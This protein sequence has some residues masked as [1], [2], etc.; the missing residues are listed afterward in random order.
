MKIVETNFM[1][2]KQKIAKRIKYNKHVNF[3]ISICQLYKRYKL[4]VFLF[5]FVSSSFNNK[6]LQSATE[7][8]NATFESKC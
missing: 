5:V 7:T 8:S 2:E 4:P 6:P 1:H 3:V